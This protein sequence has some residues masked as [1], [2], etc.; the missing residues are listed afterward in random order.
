[1]MNLLRD[2]SRNIQLEAFHVFKVFVAN[3]NK[4]K[5]ILD[6]LKRNKTK[7]IAFLNAFH[8]DRTGTLS[9]ISTN[10]LDDEQ[11]LEEKAFLIKQMT[12]L[13]S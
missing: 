2:P 3:P 13:P 12:D 1:M 6:I 5:P 10:M 9:P 4:P 11:F 7:L 8:T